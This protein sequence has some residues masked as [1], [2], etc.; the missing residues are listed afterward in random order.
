[1]PTTRPTYEL[2][3][4]ACPDDFPLGSLTLGTYRSATE[5]RLAWHDDERAVGQ[6]LP[7]VIVHCA[8]DGTETVIPTPALTF[9]REAT[10]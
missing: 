2:R 7:R 8:P 3:H 10:R 1:M 4:H 9:I 6:P 5:A